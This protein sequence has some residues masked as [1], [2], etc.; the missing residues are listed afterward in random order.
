MNEDSSVI[1]GIQKLRDFPANGKI[2]FQANDYSIAI[3]AVCDA[4]DKRNRRKI[5]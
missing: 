2:E 4:F 5:Q 1:A 3:K